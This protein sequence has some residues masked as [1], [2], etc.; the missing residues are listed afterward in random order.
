MISHID[1]LTTSRTILEIISLRSPTEEVLN[2]SLDNALTTSIRK[3]RERER[4]KESERMRE[5]EKDK[6]TER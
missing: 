4:E 2:S 3:E 5:R 6:E 1:L